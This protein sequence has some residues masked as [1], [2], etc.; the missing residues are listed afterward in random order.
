MSVG[1]KHASVGKHRRQAAKAAR[2]E[3]KRSRELARE[4]DRM[5][6]ARHGRAGHG[7]CGRKCRYSSELA[8]LRVALR[9]MRRGAPPLW[10]YRCPICHGWHLTSHPKLDGSEV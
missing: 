4:R 2:R 8:A 9:C 3:R 7:S 5:A 6:T 1:G 10:A